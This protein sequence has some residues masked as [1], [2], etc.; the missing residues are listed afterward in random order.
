MKEVGL[1]DLVDCI[2]ENHPY[3]WTWQTE[4]LIGWIQFYCRE[5]LIIANTVDGKKIDGLVMFR[6]VMKPEDGCGNDLNY[7]PE[8]SV[9]FI[10][11]TYGPTAEIRRGLIVSVIQ[12]IGRRETVAWERRGVL[13][14]YSAS[15]FVLRSLKNEGVKL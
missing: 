6:T 2:V 5:G 11:F 13:R 9:V 8:G 12:R 3:A 1:Q 14:V 10:D 4:E 7:D 15:H